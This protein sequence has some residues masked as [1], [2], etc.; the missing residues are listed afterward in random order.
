VWSKQLSCIIS[1]AVV[2]VLST[3]ASAS[4]MSV[5]ILGD[6]LILSGRVVDGDHARVKEALGADPRVRTAILRN[7]PGGHAGSGYAIGELFRTLGVA[8]AVSGY[9]YSSCSRMFLGGQDRRFTDDY[10][11]DTTNVGFHGHYDR[12]GQLDPGTVERYGLRPWIIRYSD[13]KAD[14]DL[15]DRWIAIPVNVGMLHFYHPVL[16]ETK[17]ASAFLCQGTEPARQRVFG[18]EKIGK[19]A[20]EL[21]V[22]TSTEFARSNDHGMELAP[23]RTARRSRVGAGLQRGVPALCPGL[24]GPRGAARRRR[25]W[26]PG[27][28]AAISPV[29]RC[30]QL[31]PTHISLLECRSATTSGRSAGS[32]D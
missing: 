21:G 2:S 10:P 29:R 23:S 27:A 18:C 17:G 19:N 25:A 24:G 32:G 12:N 14:P 20:L 30:F 6:Q 16:A 8:T 11:L 5:K 22:L 7:S 26:S 31:A 1:A 9:C 4:A 3:F 28:P 15:V 13:G